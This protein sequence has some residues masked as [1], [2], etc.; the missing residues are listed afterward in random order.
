MA[1]RC[2]GCAHE[3]RSERRF[4]AT[5]GAPLAAP[6]PRC[7]FANL[8]GEK[9]CGGCGA[10]LDAPA[11]AGERRQ[12][13]ILFADLAGYTRLS[14]TLDPEE[15]HR[16][17]TGFFEAVDGVCTSYGGTIDKHIG[18]NVM[19]IFGA[20]VAH[21]DDP[22]R[23]VRAGVEIHRAVAEY[24]RRV[25]RQLAVHVGIAYGEVVASGLGSAHH[26]EYTVTGDAVNLAARLQDKAVGGETLISDAVYRAASRVADAEPVGDVQVKGLAAPIAVWRLRGVRPAHSAIVHV[27]GRDE[28]LGIAA[29]HLARNPLLVV[30]GDAGIG[31]SAFCGELAR[32]AAGDR[33][34]HLA[35][36]LDFGQGHGAGAIS[37][38]VASLLG[39][40]A[41]DDELRRA[42]LDDAVARGVVAPGDRPHLAALLGIDVE[43]AGIEDRERRAQQHAALAA[44]IAAQ[45][46]P[47]LVVVE[48]VHWADSPTRARLVAAIA[49]VSA[50]GGATIVT[51]RI[52]GDPV[53]AAWR[54]AGGQVLEIDLAPLSPEAAARLA[55]DH[56]AD[57]ELVAR[58]V[59]RAGGNP[60]FLEQLVHAATRDSA[61]PGTLQG[62]V[63]ARV[64]RLPARDKAAL[65]IA[66]IAGQRCSLA[67]VRELAGDPAW[68]PD[69]LIARRLVV[70]PPAGDPDA[71]AFHHAL[72]LDGVYASLT[73][74]RRRELHR[75]AAAYFADRELALRAE[76]LERAG[77]AEAA[78]TYAAAAAERA[79]A[80][81][82]DGA[83]ALLE[84]AARCAGTQADRYAVHELAGRLHLELGD[85]TAAARAWQVAI[86]DA[87][88]AAARYRAMI[89]LAGA[90]RLSSAEGPAEVLLDEAEPLALA[91][92]D[93]VALAQCAYLRGSLAFMYRDAATCRGHHE[94]A[95]AHARR[96]G[97]PE[98]EARA[99][100]GLGDALYSEARLTEAAAAFGACA[101]VAT[102]QG[103][104]T[105]ALVNRAMQ[106]D[107][108][109]F[110]MET[111]T[112]H[113][114][115]REVIAEAVARRAGRAEALALESLALGLALAGL[116]DGLD[117]L[118]EQ[119]VRRC[120][121]LGLPIFEA[122]ARFVGIESYSVRGDEA[123]VREHAREVLEMAKGRT[124]LLG[125]LRGAQLYAAETDEERVAMMAAPGDRTF[126]GGPMARLMFRRIAIDELLRKGR[127]DLAT[128]QAEL[129]AAEL[130]DVPI[131]VFLAARGRLTAAWARGDRSPALADQLRRLRADARAHGLAC[132]LP[133]PDVS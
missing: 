59:E 92:D 112:A 4:C 62:L 49:A 27:V 101:D 90:H 14:T 98:W 30:R 117:E 40:A 110:L 56:L 126:A 45:P 33:A 122:W 3:N 102:A 132:P 31:K 99:L 95:L 23:A 128:S 123:A 76:H 71:L 22:E 18:D 72:I 91:H 38:L 1:M 16:L 58:C 5:C 15:V 133:D 42:A 20:P 118:V 116:Y 86:D 41:A 83:L 28:E 47:P 131:A 6:C 125:L 96:A 87:P 84:R 67:L 127:W 74:T 106:A 130:P 69:E 44:L 64:D 65:Q 104:H 34:V 61:L 113:R 51:T 57:R 100:S 36:V 94:R 25:G 89:G 68:T 77:D 108:M 12:V 2:P 129:L 29:A 124:Y 50:R 78:S 60:F 46:R 26:Q 7:K 81:D 120:R 66:A 32:R 8:P 114:L 52:D 39:A 24:S 55:A 109:C 82:V 93:E 10:G 53:D 70:R 17:L 35:Q 111:E 107:S 85:A 115:L 79:G 11:P 121:E 119:A 19:A 75:A 97:S 63:L 103:L 80:H 54:D 105:Y 37:T 43:G 88:D 13:A 21:G 9:F 48:D 73:F